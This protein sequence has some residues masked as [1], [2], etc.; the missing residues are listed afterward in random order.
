MNRCFLLFIQLLLLSLP[1]LADEITLPELFTVARVANHDTLNIR[2]APKNTAA[3][4]GQLAPDATGIEVVALST[5]GEWAQVNTG[6]TAGWVARR[7]LRFDTTGWKANQLPPHLACYG[8]EPFWSLRQHSAGHL[9]L[10]E[11]GI[12]DRKLSL[13]TVVGRGFEQDRLRGLTAADTSGPIAAVI[14]PALC[15]DGMSDRTFAL[16]ATIIVE[17]HGTGARL[18]TGC[19]SIAPQ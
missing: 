13:H 3:I 16:N 14:Q 15:S 6:E 4:L 8:T 5:D 7:F 12:N 11:P 2:S 10:S 9:V 1:T 18:L 17:D 19:C